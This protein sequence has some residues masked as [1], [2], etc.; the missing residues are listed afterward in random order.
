MFILKADQLQ[1]EIGGKELFRNATLEVHEKERIAIIGMN[2]VGKTTLLQ[3]LAGRVA[4]VKGT[5]SFGVEPEEIG[6][7]L[8]GPDEDWSISAREWVESGNERMFRLKKRLKLAER[9]IGQIIT[10]ESEENYNNA[11]QSYMEQKGYE[12][13]A[14]AEKALGRLRIPRDVWELPFSSL[15]GGQKTRVRL[16]R[17]I[18]GSPKLLILDEPT[19]HLDMDTIEFLESWL[20]RYN[21]SVLF[22]SHERSFL[23][24]TAT[25]LYELTEKGTRRYEGGYSDFKMEKE[26]EVKTELALYEKQEEQRRK[27]LETIRT[28]K[29][30]HRK[31]DLH[32]SVRDPYAQGKAAKQAVKVKAK[33]KALERL[34]SV[35]IDKPAEEKQ[36]QAVIPSGEFSPR[37]MLELRGVE[38]AYG[39]RTIIADCSLHINRGDRIT[40]VGRNGAGKTTLLKVMSGQIVPRKGEVLVNPQLR[41]GYFFQELESLHDKFSL[42]DELLLLPGMTQSEARNILACFLFRKEDV[43]KRVED[44]SMGE[45]CRAAFVKLLFSDAHILMLDEPAN[46][47]D[48]PARERIEEALS[49]YPGA[50]IIVA[51]DPF[52]LRRVANKVLQIE[53]GQVHVYEGSYLEWENREAL[54]GDRL[55]ADNERQ[56]LELEL[57]QLM[58]EEPAETASEQKKQ[59]DAIKELKSKIH[60][61]SQKAVDGE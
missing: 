57:I 20:K 55:H 50:V 13:E 51:H 8:P 40:L 14:Q 38:V 19:N 41:I 3:S 60:R 46:Y 47:L 17:T 21:G 53:G 5:I 48:I 22:T 31:A 26:H 18:A 1:L 49:V 11:L 25:C 16:A 7:M 23:D 33:E 54:S 37:R 29:E 34:E 52:L 43:Y 45:K 15:S 12:W 59:L 44:L 6:W 32:A 9:T 36:I 28:Y 24:G 30:W 58:G 2:G 27:L 56:L 4:P 10:P 42:L 61:L 35:R 39:S